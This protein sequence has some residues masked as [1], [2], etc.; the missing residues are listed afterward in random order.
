MCRPAQPPDRPQ[1]ARWHTRGV[2]AMAGTFGYELDLGLLSDEEKE[3][4]RT[5][6]KT[7]RDLQPLL[8]DGRY[9]R[10]TDAMTDTYF[11]AWQQTASDASR[12][13]VSIVVVDPKPNP[14]PIHITLKVWTPTP[15]TGI[16]A[17]ARSTPARPCAMP[18]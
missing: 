4:I 2:V 12:A 7:C 6:I 1:H 18:A 16:P 17:R 5:Q 9:D 15:I 11:T 10:L 8:I 3:Q 13:V 14:W